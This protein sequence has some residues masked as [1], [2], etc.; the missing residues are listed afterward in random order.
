MVLL[1]NFTNVNVTKEDA[2][3]DP[4]YLIFPCEIL[5]C[6]SSSLKLPTF[7]ETYSLGMTTERYLDRGGQVNTTIFLTPTQT[8]ML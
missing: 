4:I 8:R 7:E 6:D 2:A 1:S 3:L 5:E